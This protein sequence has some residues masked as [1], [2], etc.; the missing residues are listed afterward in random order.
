[1]KLGSVPRGSLDRGGVRWSCSSGQAFPRQFDTLVASALARKKMRLAGRNWRIL[2]QEAYYPMYHKLN[3]SESFFPSIVVIET[4][5]PD[6]GMLD[7]ASQHRCLMDVSCRTRSWPTRKG[8]EKVDNNTAVSLQ[9]DAR[10]AK[11]GRHAS[12]RG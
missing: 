12:L 1:M 2:A 5:K 10:S 8:L 4:T 7:N 6:L 11:R 9:A 3:L